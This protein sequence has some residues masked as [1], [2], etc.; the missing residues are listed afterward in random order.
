MPKINDI[1]INM[2]RPLPIQSSLAM[3]QIGEHLQT[4]RKLRGLTAQQLADKASVARYTIHRL[5]KGDPAVSTATLLNVC[6][7]LGVLDELTES[8]N[9]LNTDLGRA[10]LTQSLPKRI[11]GNK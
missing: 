5:E 10:R 11:N 7:V 3:Q 1:R 6:R 9:P 4:W 8:L 2:K